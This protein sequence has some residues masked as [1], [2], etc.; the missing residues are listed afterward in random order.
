MDRLTMYSRGIADRRSSKVATPS[1]KGNTESTMRFTWRETEPPSS[2][3]SMMPAWIRAS[4]NLRLR[5]PPSS[6]E[7]W[8][9]WSSVMR[10]RATRASPRRSFLRLLA[11]KTMRPWSKKMVLTAL[12]D[13]TCRS[14]LLRDPARARRVSAMGVVPRS[15]SIA[16]PLDT[17]GL[18]PVHPV[19]R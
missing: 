16:G 18:R 5:S 1:E 19:P 15:M 2:V 4:P 10:P 13:C 17:T 11:A 7:A 3:L 14:P 12:P 6:A 8:L 9:Y